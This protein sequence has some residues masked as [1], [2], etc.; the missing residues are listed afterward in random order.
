LKTS[1][2]A[3]AAE[4]MAVPFLQQLETGRPPRSIGLAHPVIAPY[5]AFKTSDGE[6]VCLLLHAV[7][8]GR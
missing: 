6:S 2:F 5:G 3:G 7:S 4:L 1:L 8:W